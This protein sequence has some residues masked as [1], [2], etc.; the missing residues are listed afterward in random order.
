M[1]DLTQRARCFHIATARPHPN[2]CLDTGGTA[3]GCALEKSLR[4]PLAALSVLAALRPLRSSDLRVGLLSDF[5]DPQLGLTLIQHRAKCRSD[6]VV[7]EAIP[8]LSRT[9]WDHALAA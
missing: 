9:L 4:D 6:V 7:A 5:C 2:D 1:W 8:K 3:A